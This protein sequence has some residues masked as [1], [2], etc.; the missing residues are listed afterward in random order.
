VIVSVS[1]GT[2]GYDQEVSHG[3]DASMWTAERRKNVMSGARMDI[4]RPDAVTRIIK[5]RL[6]A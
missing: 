4:E 3:V 5:A 2:P 1:A 6:L